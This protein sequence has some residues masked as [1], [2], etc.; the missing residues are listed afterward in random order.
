MPG[1]PGEIG[2]KLWDAEHLEK[3]H[4]RMFNIIRQANPEL[5]IVILPAPCYSPDDNQKARAAIVKKTYKDAVASGDK[6]VYFIDGKKLMKY[7]KTDGFADYLGC[8]PNDLGYY[9]MAQ[10][11]IPLLKK[12][13]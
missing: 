5:P 12:L 13:I 7:A 3:T 9:S 11:L 6:N 1:S 2:A 10:A 4:Q 8:H